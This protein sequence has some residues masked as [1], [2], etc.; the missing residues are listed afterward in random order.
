MNTFSNNTYSYCQ[1]RIPQLYKRVSARLCGLDW[2]DG[3]VTDLQ[4]IHW[5]T[6]R[7]VYVLEIRHHA[8]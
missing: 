2:L 3:T 4:I 5:A 8:V 7:H 1:V 6:L